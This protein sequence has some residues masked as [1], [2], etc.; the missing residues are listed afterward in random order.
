MIRQIYDDHDPETLEILQRFE[1]NIIKLI[2]NV[3]VSFDPDVLFINAYIF[4]EFP[5]LLERI[6]TKF[7]KI[8]V[9]DTPIVLSKNVETASLYGVV[10]K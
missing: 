10:H 2:N 8:S 7:A 3:I 9:R 4:K 6:R 1:N 5:E